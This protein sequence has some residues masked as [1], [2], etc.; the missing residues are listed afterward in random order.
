MTAFVLGNGLSRADIDPNDLLK[1]GAVYGCNALYRTHRPTALVA[2]DRAIAEEIQRSGYALENRFHTRRP[3][4]DLGGKPIPQPYFGFSSGP[5][6]AALAA[7]DHHQEIYLLGFD[8]GPAP[9]GLFN[10]V[11]ADTPHYRRSQDPPTYTGNWNRQIQRICQDFPRVQ[12]IR[13]YGPT[14]AEIPE[15][16]GIP[17]LARCSIADLLQRINKPKDL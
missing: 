13:V 3:L 1:L 6:A 16:A 14:T 4:P 11:Y 15:F 17:N 5:A 10:N 8:M 7:L 9:S 2:T 12:F